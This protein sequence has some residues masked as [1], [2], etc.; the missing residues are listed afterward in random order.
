MADGKRYYW[1]RLHDDFFSSVRIKKLRRMDGGDTYVI[2]YLKLQLKSIKSDGVLT[3]KGYEQ[4]FVDELAL[5]IDESPDD[6]R[7]TLA[8]LL[9][10]GLA[11]TTDNVNF[12]LPYA[13]D[14]TGSEGASA[15]RWRDWKSR[16]DAKTL[17]SNESLTQHKQITNG[18]KEIEKEIEKEKEIDR[19]SALFKLF[20]D[21]YPKKVGK[22]AAVKSFTKALKQTDVDTMLKAIDT[23]KQS[24]QWRRD[25]G[26][27]I[28]NPATWLNQGRW[29]D[30]VS[31]DS[32]EDSS[33]RWNIR[34]DV[35]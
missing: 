35:G 8:Y 11:E 18:E 32:G 27:Y 17:D 33:S 1:L 30:V 3:W 22:Q 13:V 15:K 2:I 14:N 26:R 29:E 16:Q 25:N 4:D 24:D 10:C 20:W 34:A 19:D 12:F 7:V 31:G 9:S 28:P 6:I 5:D 23:Q 21:A